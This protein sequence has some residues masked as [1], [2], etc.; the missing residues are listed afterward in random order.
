MSSLPH[1]TSFWS[2]SFNPLNPPPKTSNVGHTKFIRNAN[3]FMFC[4]FIL[5]DA[6]RF[7]EQEHK[8]T[9]LLNG[10][11][12][13]QSTVWKVFQYGVISGLYFLLFGLNTEIYGVNLCI[14]SG[15]NTG[16]YGHE[17]LRIWTL[18]MQW[19]CIKLK[20]QQGG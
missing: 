1:K 18:L 20:T 5:K 2:F 8:R 13:N 19:S 11:I 7:H 3:P 6:T 9:L 15:R 4:F 16:K 10:M 17:K 12:K 14:Q